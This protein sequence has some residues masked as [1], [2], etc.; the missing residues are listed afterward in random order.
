MVALII[1]AIVAVVILFQL[2]N[3]LGRKVGFRA[4]DKPVTVKGDDFGDLSTKTD[5]L[6]EASRMPNLEMLKTRDANF[7]ELNF[8]EKA[9]ESYE[10]VVIAFHK[11]E[12]DAVKDKLS[13]TVYG[14]FAKA[15]VGRAAPEETLSFVD[16]PKA[17][18]DHID[19]KD[20]VA[21]IRVRF[22]SELVYEKTEAPAE[23]AVPPTKADAPKVHRS[24]KRTAE[25]WTFQK[26]MKV[27]NSPW[28]LTKVEAAK[29]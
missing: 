3:V 15:L 12:L 8:L 29:A 22:L 6:P 1:F 20:E 19:F 16:Q 21:Q 24:H 11:G 28:L 9:R 26:G 7:N 4:E 14:I 18:I 17:D 10:Q 23:S 13:D 5:K 25:Y 2:Y 27:A